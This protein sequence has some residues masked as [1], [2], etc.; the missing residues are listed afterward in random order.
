MHM[1]I[2]KD[3]RREIV[4]NF[5]IFRRNRGWTLRQTAKILE[6][7][8][9]FLSRIESGKKKPSD[10]CLAKMTLVNTVKKEN[11]WT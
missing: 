10:S 11:Q 2:S 7:C 9:S 4:A 5:F 3:E 6:I 8:P 1:D